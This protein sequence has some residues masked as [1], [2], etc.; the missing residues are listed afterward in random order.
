M[1]YPQ[2]VTYKKAGKSGRHVIFDTNMMKCYT[3]QELMEIKAEIPFE[4]FA[5]PLEIAQLALFLADDK[6]SYITGQVIQIDGGF[7]L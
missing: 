6:S 5:N 7:G 2:N 1:V 4:R 3:E